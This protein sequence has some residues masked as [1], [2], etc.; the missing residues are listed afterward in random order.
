MAQ[1][2]QRAKKSL[3]PESRNGF[4]KRKDTPELSDTE[5]KAYLEFAVDMFALMNGLNTAL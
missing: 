4:V 1:P 3:G 5:Q 2:G